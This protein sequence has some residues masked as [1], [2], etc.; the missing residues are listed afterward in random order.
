MNSLDSFSK[1]L[2]AASA[3]KEQERK[4][5]NAK[6]GE[7]VAFIPDSEDPAF[8]VGFWKATDGGVVSY[9]KYHNGFDPYSRIGYSDEF[10]DILNRVSKGQ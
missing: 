2:E 10:I 6:L 3:R 4:E 1:G 8:G 5:F 9:R 7:P